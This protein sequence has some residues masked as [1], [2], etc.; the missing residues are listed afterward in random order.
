MMLLPEYWR[1]FSQ[2]IQQAGGGASQLRRS[3]ALRILYGGLAVA[4]EI[5]GTLAPA[6]TFSLE[7]FNLYHSK[8]VEDIID[9]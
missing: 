1:I 6:E 7:K 4:V 2:E 8:E 5:C 3:S 9:F